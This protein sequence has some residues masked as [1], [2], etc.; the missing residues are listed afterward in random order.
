MGRRTSVR[1][2]ILSSALALLLH[3]T[4]AAAE[5]CEVPFQ[6]SKLTIHKPETTLTSIDVP[7]TFVAFGTDAVRTLH[8][9]MVRCPSAR[10]EHLMLSDA[11]YFDMKPN[12]EFVQAFWAESYSDESLILVDEAVKAANKDPTP[13]TDPVNAILD[14]AASRVKSLTLMIYS[15]SKEDGVDILKRT[16]PRLEALTVRNYR[17]VEPLEKAATAFPSLTHLHIVQL[18]SASVPTTSEFLSNL[19]RLTHLRF[20]GAIDLD[21]ALPP[22]LNPAYQP[23]ALFDQ[24]DVIASKDT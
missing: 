11:T 9:Y 7:A 10:P 21:F 22:D 12:S 4:A 17:N 15:P 16:W 24:T 6:D 5:D 23:D 18:G 2:T 20:S 8:E 13:F 14:L 1:H 19:H 3:S